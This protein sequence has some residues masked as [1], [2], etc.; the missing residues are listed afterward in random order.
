MRR[1]SRPRRSSVVRVRHPCRS[2]RVAFPSRGRT[3]RREQRS[4]GC[5]SRRRRDRAHPP[6]VDIAREF[7]FRHRLRC[8]RR[9]WCGGR[10]ARVPT[11]RRRDGLRPPARWAPACRGW[12]DPVGHVAP[13]TNRDAVRR[14]SRGRARLRRRAG[15]D[16]GG[17][18]GRGR[19]PG[20]RR[21]C[22]S[23]DPTRPA[24]PSPS[25]T[26]RTRTR[27]MHPGRWAAGLDR[28][29]PPTPIRARASRRDETPRDPGGPRPVCRHRR[30]REVPRRDVPAVPPPLPVGVRRTPDPARDPRRSPPAPPP[31]RCR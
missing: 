13:V 23:P 11:R 20:D 30:L 9:P 4:P 8:N 15:R 12:I 27:P 29:A 28:R 10:R 18:N 17:C 26:G 19:R 3:S 6:T 24:R 2:C 5:S 31:H 14:E 16:S 22:R 21:G 7:V 1:C 25:A